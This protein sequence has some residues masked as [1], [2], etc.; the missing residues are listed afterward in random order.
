M[1]VWQL[2]LHRPPLT[3]AQNEPLWEWLA[4]DADL[5]FRHEAQTTQAEV[6]ADWVTAQLQAA[7]DQA[8]HVPEKI[9]VFRPQALSLLTLAAKNLGL[10][11]IPTR[12]TPALHQWLRQ[13]A[14]IYP[15]LGN[16]TGTV[17]DP[18]HLESPPPLPLAENLW[19]DR[20]GFVTLAAGDF[21]RTFPHEPIPIAQL[22][23]E[24]L[25]SSLGLAST[26]PLPGIV[27][28]GGRQA[29]ALAQWVQSVNPA[30][31]RYM[32]GDPDGLILD[33]GLC[34]RWVM[35][36][37]ADSD[38]A[39]AGQQFEQRKAAS[40]GLHFLLVRPD[41]SGMTYTGLWLLRG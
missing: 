18:L 12:Y 5:G 37:F 30:T 31:L 9:Q 4:C 34:D 29:M 20:W 10:T 16:F 15:T 32:A 22:P 24:W 8:G 17:Y 27:I 19:G 40:Q 33:A 23:P 2:D 1:T 6:S 25:P 38:M 35:T 13:K 28:D 14:E 7:I 36:T 26:T 11:T 3:N 41:D 21:E 39:Q